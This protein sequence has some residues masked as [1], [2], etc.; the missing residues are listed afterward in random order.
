MEMMPSCGFANS[1]R[2]LLLRTV[3]F[4][5]AHL[6]GDFLVQ[7]RFLK[8]LLVRSLLAPYLLPQKVA[9]LSVL[10]LLYSVFILLGVHHCWLFLFE[11]LHCCRFHVRQ[12]RCLTLED[13]FCYE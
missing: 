2:E 3:P 1:S 13:H 7:Q 5:W 4:P 8:L 10:W 11:S 12:A 6:Q 9:R